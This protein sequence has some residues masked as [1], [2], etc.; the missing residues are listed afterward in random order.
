MTQSH[1]INTLWLLGDVASGAKAL[2]SKAT[3]G[4]AE[5]PPFRTTIY[6]MA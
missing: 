6:E 1:F 4:G 3:Y 5:A 2:I